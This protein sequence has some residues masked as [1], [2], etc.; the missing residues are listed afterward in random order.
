MV[1]SVTALVLLI[2]CASAATT[3]AGR[4]T[5]TPG[6]YRNSANTICADERRQTMAFLA[7][8]KTLAQYLTSE[9]SVVRSTVA[10]L[11]K[12]QPPPTLASLHGKV[13][14]T[15]RGELSEF[16]TLAKQAKA[17]RL[18]LAQW[19]QNP[20][21]RQLDQRELDLW[22]KIGAKTCSGA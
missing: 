2:A 1:G 13:V 21:L 11:E 5:L 9:L 17:G 10:S 20:Q 8:A 6:A 15:V 4:D 19:Q 14:A 3:S 22:K 18:S 12:L 7:R 16:T